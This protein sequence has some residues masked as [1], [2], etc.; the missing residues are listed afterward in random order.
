MKKA[1]KFIPLL[2][3]FVAVIIIVCK[4]SYFRKVSSAKQYIEKTIMRSMNDGTGIP[5]D[6]LWDTL[7]I[8]ANKETMRNHERNIYDAA[9]AILEDTTFEVSNVKIENDLITADVVFHTY[10]VGEVLS[11]DDFQTNMVLYAE[12]QKEDSASTKVLQEKVIQF[13]AEQV[14]DSHK[15][16]DTNVNVV[17][18]QTDENPS[19]YF[20]DALLSAMFGGTDT[21]DY[22]ISLSDITLGDNAGDGQMQ[23][24]QEY[25]E[26]RILNLPSSN[27]TTIS[28]PT[29]PISMGHEGVFD[30]M[31]YFY[32]EKRCCLKISVDEIIRGDAANNLMGTDPANGSPDAG[33]EYLAAKV[34]AECV[35]SATGTVN[36]SMD[37]FSFLDESG[38]Y[39]KNVFAIGLAGSTDLKEGEKGEIFVVF[40]IVKGE[41]GYILFNPY[42]DT[43]LC[44][45]IND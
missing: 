7:H 15:V 20:T 36:I 24:I 25:D 41:G 6:K 13:I 40:Q 33:M 5:A 12:S 42:M 8:S 37:D 28:T 17:L 14:I 23:K 19:V 21:Y 26:T 29:N 16:T 30:N 35:E 39:A 4:G 45:S 32:Q 44:F 3:L 27:R 2:M 11:S 18:S 34:S 10:N 9:K 22:Q 1:I 38:R 43:A 31:D